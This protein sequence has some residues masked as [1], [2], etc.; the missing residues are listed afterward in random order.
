VLKES[1]KHWTSNLTA[2]RDGRF[3]LYAQVEIHGSILMAEKTR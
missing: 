3:I 2:T 1:P